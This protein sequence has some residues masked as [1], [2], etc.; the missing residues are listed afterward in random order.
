M[1]DRVMRTTNKESC[2]KNSKYKCNKRET[3]AYLH[4]LNAN[5]FNVLLVDSSDINV[6][7]KGKKQVPRPPTKYTK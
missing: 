7:T 3:K 2:E 1:R 4:T 5:A 6:N